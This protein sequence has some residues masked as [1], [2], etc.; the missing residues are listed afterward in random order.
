VRKTL[1]A[2]VVPFGEVQVVLSGHFADRSGI[3]V[4]T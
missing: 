2:D 4:S 3:L 1:G